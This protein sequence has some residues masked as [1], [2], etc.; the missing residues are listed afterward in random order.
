MNQQAVPPG[1]H[2]PV[3][4]LRLD[5]VG[6]VRVA[7]D[8]Y[9]SVLALITDAL[10]R[11]R[12]APEQWRRRVLASLSPGGV[13]AILPLATPSHSVSP[14]CVTPEN[15]AREVSVSDQVEGLHSLSADELLRDVESVFTEPPVHWQGV[16]RRPLAWLH[17]YADAMAEVWPSVQPLWARAAP[18]LEHEVRRV[19]IAAMR[20]DLG[21]VL[22]RLHPASRF[23]DGVLKIRDPEPARFELR[24]RPLVLVPMLSGKQALICN[25]E[26]DDAVWI[27][28]PLPRACSNQ[29]WAR[30]APSSCWPW[31]SRGPCRSSPA[32][33]AWH[34]ARSRTT[35]T[36]WPLP[37]SYGGRSAAA[38]SGS[39]GP[40]AGMP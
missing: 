33:R 38:R 16:L 31:N 12:G 28:Y 1:Q 19:G 18:L 13:R 30:F 3:T 11:R 26:R 35:A 36:G 15:P 39:P 10:G 25:L 37:D 17:S 6:E 29:C 34:R 9:I 40:A 2:G 24:A 20:G 5:R 23:D 22:D 4:E 8:P 21:L 32:G 27:A 7:L 14:D